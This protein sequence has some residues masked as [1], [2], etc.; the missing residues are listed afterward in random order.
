MKIEITGGSH[1]DRQEAAFPTVVKLN[2]GDL[3]L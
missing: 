1:V 2:H 3:I